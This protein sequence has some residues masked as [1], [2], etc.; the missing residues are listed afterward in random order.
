VHKG[1]YTRSLSKGTGNLNECRV[2]R[3]ATEKAETLYGL[4]RVS[5]AYLSVDRLS[6]Y[7]PSGSLL[8]LYSFVA[9]VA[10]PVLMKTRAEVDHP[11]YSFGNERICSP[12]REG[13]R[14]TQALEES[15][16]LFWSEVALQTTGGLFSHL[17]VEIQECCGRLFFW[18]VKH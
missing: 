18:G 10:H 5:L 17:G 14:T 1:P 11:S 2:T 9:P 4:G 12:V 13:N 3:T 16:I 8:P 15:G 7:M 6:T